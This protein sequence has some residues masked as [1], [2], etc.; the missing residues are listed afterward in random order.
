MVEAGRGP[1]SPASAG[2][3]APHEWG[4]TIVPMPH[5]YPHQPT[6]GLACRVR[7]WRS[8]PAR[9]RGVSRPGEA[10]PALLRGT[11]PALGRRQPSREGLPCRGGTWP[12]RP[13]DGESRLPHRP[14]PHCLGFQPAVRL[15]ARRYGPRSCCSRRRWWSSMTWVLQQLWSNMRHR[16]RSACLWASAAAGPP[17]GR[18]RFQP[19]ARPTC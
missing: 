14:V 5:R 7:P 13:A 8:P 3:A 9:P 19:P 18:Y 17:S 16:L 4:Q 6:N 15:L 2:A 12:S 1:P 10:Q 11:A